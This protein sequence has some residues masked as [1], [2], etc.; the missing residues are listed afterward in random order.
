MRVSSF[1][2]RFLRM[3]CV[4]ALRFPYAAYKRTRRAIDWPLTV[5]GALCGA[6]AR[7][8]TRATLLEIVLVSARL[9]R[10]RTAR[11]SIVCVEKQMN[12]TLVERKGVPTLLIPI[13]PTA[14]TGAYWG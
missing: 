4:G 9:N 14:L 1:F 5:H 11:R 7:I 12:P 10:T 6:V 8:E 3:A 2:V 13:R